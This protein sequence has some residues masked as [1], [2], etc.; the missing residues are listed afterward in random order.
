MQIRRPL[1]ALAL[2]LAVA[3]GLVWGD[4]PAQAVVSVAASNTTT[5]AYS[6]TVDGSPESVYLSGLVQITMKVVRDP[7]FGRPPVVLLSI[8]LSN[9]SGVGQTTGRKYVTA[10]GQDLIRPLVATDVVEI[11]FPFFPSGSGGAAQAR[12]ALASFTLRYNVRTGAFLGGAASTAVDATERL[13][14][15]ANQ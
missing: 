4:D 7:D 14:P 12:Q 8:D 1:F 5:I 9:V 6:G 2:S 11:T 15:I 3:G 10:G 13:A